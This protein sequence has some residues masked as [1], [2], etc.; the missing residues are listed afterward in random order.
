MC[1][2]RVLINESEVETLNWYT[3]KIASD[4]FIHFFFT[5]ERRKR[6]RLPDETIVS[7]DD[8]YACML[9]QNKYTTSDAI[10]STRRSKNIQ[11]S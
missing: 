7:S 11:I 3:I 4:I 5:K 9:I 1:T 10:T 8:K 6:E 2:N